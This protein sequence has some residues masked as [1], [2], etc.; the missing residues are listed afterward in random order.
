MLLDSALAYHRELDRQ[1]TQISPPVSQLLPLLRDPEF[2]RV[3][4]VTVPEATPVHEAARLQED[5][6]RAQI[7]PY[8]W[9]VNQ[10]LVPLNVTDPVLMER[11]HH[12][13]HFIAMVQ[14]KLADRITLVPWQEIPPIGLAGLRQ[15]VSTPRS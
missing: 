15:I 14:N 5:L 9:V 4:I 1:S 3:L 11:Q 6:R 12:E 7:E 10:S 13:R 8:A 2:T